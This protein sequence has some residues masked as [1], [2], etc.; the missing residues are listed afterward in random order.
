MDEQQLKEVFEKLKEDIALFYSE[1][2]WC[3]I[4]GQLSRSAR[5]HGKGKRISVDDIP[6]EVNMPVKWPIEAVQERC[7]INILDVRDGNVEISFEEFKLICETL[8]ANITKELKLL[9][10][11]YEEIKK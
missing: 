11:I 4:N 2:I 6:P 5:F 9:V 3:F 7:G 8:N 10:F 1:I